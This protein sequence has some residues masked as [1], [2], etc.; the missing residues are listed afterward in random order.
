MYRDV[1]LLSKL[2]HG[3]K[4]VEMKAGQYLFQE[5]KPLDKVGSEAKRKGKGQK[6]NVPSSNLTNDSCIASIVIIPLF[7]AYTY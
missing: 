6:I 5:G 2:C 7:S 4:C 3:V 1:P